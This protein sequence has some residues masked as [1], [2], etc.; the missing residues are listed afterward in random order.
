MD[1][2]IYLRNAAM[3]QDKYGVEHP[4]DPTDEGVFAEK[5]SVTRQEFFSAGR[6]G[7]NP[8]FVFKVFHGD[9][10]GETVVIYDG[11]PYA[12]YRT[13]RTDDDYIEIYVRREGGTNGQDHNG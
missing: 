2:V 1:C 4:E 12:V 13:Y 3:V 11:N 8:E 5:K 10:H 7:L 6:M 9:Y